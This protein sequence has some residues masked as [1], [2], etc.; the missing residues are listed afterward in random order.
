MNSLNRYRPAKQFRCPPLVGRNAPFG[1]EERIQTADGTHNY[2]STSDVVGTFAE[3]N[4]Q[5]RKAW[6][7]LIGV[8]ETTEESKS[9]SSDTT[10]NGGKLSSCEKATSM[11][12][13]SLLTGSGRNLKGLMDEH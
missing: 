9:M 5:G 7:L 10:A 12:A 3:M 2:Q 4:D 8:T 13:C 6:N 11:N 1:Y